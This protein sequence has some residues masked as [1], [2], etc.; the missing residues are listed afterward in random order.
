MSAPAPKRT[1]IAR[2]RRSRQADGSPMPVL[3]VPY[4]FQDELDRDAVQR[5]ARSLGGRL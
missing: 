2:L 4:L 3:S 1:Q 5:I